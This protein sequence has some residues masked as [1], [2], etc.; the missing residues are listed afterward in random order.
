MIDQ[1]QQTTYKTTPPWLNIFSTKSNKSKPMI[2]HV[3][4]TQQN[5]AWLNNFNKLNQTQAMIDHLQRA[6]YKTQTT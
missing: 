2:D 3:Q 1:L 5:R 6:T 4:Q